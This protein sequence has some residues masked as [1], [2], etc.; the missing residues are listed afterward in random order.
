MTRK[1]PPTQVSFSFQVVSKAN[2]G[3]YVMTINYKKDLNP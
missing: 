3:D 2:K 1:Y